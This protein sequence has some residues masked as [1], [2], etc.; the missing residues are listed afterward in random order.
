[1]RTANDRLQ[2]AVRDFA[3]Q[4]LRLFREGD[5][6]NL[7]EDLAGFLGYGVE[8]DV[9]SGDVVVVSKPPRAYSEEDLRALQGEARK[10]LEGVVSL[11]DTGSGV[12]PGLE[13]SGKWSAV[14]RKAGPVLLTVA[15]SVRDGFLFKL[16]LLLWQEGV[17][18]VRRCP[19]CSQLF[20]RVKRQLYC[21]RTCS[22]RVNMRAYLERQG[23]R[24]TGPRR[25][26]REGRS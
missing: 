10:M 22:T 1:M 20:W 18:H 3:Q 24:A 12:S 19:E 16:L 21:S 17:D 13:L 4:D 23:K 8:Q 14:A 26:R 9:S 25:A 15:T 5:W 11:R 2:W 7:R 6:L